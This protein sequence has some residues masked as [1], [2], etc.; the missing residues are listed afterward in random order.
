MRALFSLHG[1]YRLVIFLAAAVIV[2]GAVF[3]IISSRTD[4]WAKEDQAIRIAALDQR[5]KAKSGKPIPRFVSLKKGRVYV[6]RGPS[7]DYQVA[8]V[9]V[10]KDLPIEII[11]EFERWRR[12]RDNDGAEGWIFHALLSDKRTALITPW[13]PKEDTIKLYQAKGKTDKVIALV[14]PGAIGEITSCDGKWCTF[15]SQGYSGWL[16][17]KMLWGV[18][19]GENF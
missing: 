7:K 17:Q 4:L 16:P 5:T 12:I 6:R 15:S 1:T 2:G 19:P 9:F 13:R 11:A 10:R 14:Q 18:Y 3:M 8:W